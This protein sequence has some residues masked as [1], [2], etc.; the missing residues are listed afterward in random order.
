VSEV[1]DVFIGAGGDGALGEQDE[2]RGGEAL[3]GK[4][5]LQ[6]GEGAG[7]GGVGARDEVVVGRIDEGDDDEAGGE[8]P[9]S[10]A[11][12]RAARIGVAGESG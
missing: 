11:L 3:V 2:A 5:G 7:G 6:Q 1:E 10:S 12:R 8:A 4:P 9:W